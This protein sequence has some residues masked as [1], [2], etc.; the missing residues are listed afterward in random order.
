MLIRWLC[1]FALTQAVELPIYG[2]TRR[3]MPLTRRLAIGFGAT[4]ATHPWVWFILPEALQTPLGWWGYVVVAEL[5]AW[6]A[7][8]L[9]LTACGVSPRTAVL[10]ILCANAASFAAGLTLTA[11]GV[12]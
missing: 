5:F 11:L 3:S 12:P 6:A 2:A 4:A 7:E 10:A 9:F 8:A 1:R